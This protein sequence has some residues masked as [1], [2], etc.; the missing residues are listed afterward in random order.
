MNWTE[1]ESQKWQSVAHRRCLPGMAHELRLMLQGIY[2]RE[3]TGNRP[4][5]ISITHSCFR[6][7]HPKMDIIE[8]IKAMPED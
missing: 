5:L 6:E 4:A 2:E 7:E 8:P 1:T 3:H